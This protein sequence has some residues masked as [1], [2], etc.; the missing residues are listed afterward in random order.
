MNQGNKTILV[1]GVHFSPAY[2][3]LEKMQKMNRFQ[4]AYIG[5]KYALRNSKELSLD[6]QAI[7]ALGIPFYPL[8]TGQF[9]RG[10]TIANITAFI[11]YLQALVKAVGI[12]RKL[13]P[14]VVVSFGGYIAVPVCLAA[15]L[16]RI[17]VITHEQ[18]HVLGLANRIIARFAKTV[19]ISWPDTQAIPKHTPV[20]L[21]GNPIR[22]SFYISRTTD[23]VNFGNRSLPLIY[24]T[25]GSLGSKSINNTIAEILPDLVDKY[26][27]LHQ[28]GNLNRNED[29]RM[30]TDKKE[31][32]PVKLRE[33]YQV[34][35]HIS[36]DEVG[37]I[38]SE[39]KLLIGRSGSN[40]VTEVSEKGIPALFI[41]LPWSAYNEQEMNAI[42]LK[43]SS[44]AEL[45]QQDR[46]TSHSL[47]NLIDKMI[48]EENHYR[49]KI[50]T[51]G[52]QLKKPTEKIIEV[53]EQIT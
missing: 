14:G 26:R 2:A 49:K 52:R 12:I 22:D 20:V 45:L 35:T 3:V 5:R 16:L 42:M 39:A 11:V 51:P 43:K 23:K 38:L 32:L 44:Q 36:P 18:T 29:Y 34:Y 47:L 30:L 46:L 1:C 9:Q 4:L 40:T 15:Y 28:C 27:L 25:G 24:I 50:G 21:T 8:V 7:E 19:C 31:A 53:I 13:K 41:P 33:N 17:P 37:P 10:I 48:A 6:Y